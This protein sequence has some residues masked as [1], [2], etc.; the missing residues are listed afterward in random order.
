MR[1]A[2]LW[3][4]LSAEHKPEAQTVKE[5][6]SIVIDEAAAVGSVGA[7]ELIGCLRDSRQPQHVVACGDLD[8]LRQ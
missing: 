4:I 1:T 6:A 5:D 8:V 7:V 3:G 2:V